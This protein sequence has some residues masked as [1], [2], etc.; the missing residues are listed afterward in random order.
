MSK[1]NL[2]HVIK[3]DDLTSHNVLSLPRDSQASLQLGHVRIRPVLFCLTYNNLSYARLGTMMKWWSAYPVPKQLPEPYNDESQYGIVPCWGFGEVVESQVEDFEPGRLIFGYWPYCDLICDY[4]L[5]KGDAK[6]HWC[7]V[8]EHRKE[9]MPIYNRYIV[10]DAS[11]RLGK[12]GKK[13]VDDLAMEA[14]FLVWECGYLL[15]Q[16]ILG[17]PY[18]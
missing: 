2:V 9:L 16:V 3:K 17:K 12:L 18:V 6:G 7:E 15:N 13:E 8:S 14:V 10:K 1:Q 5:E 4:K 11:S